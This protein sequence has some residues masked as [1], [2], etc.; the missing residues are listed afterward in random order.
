MLKVL[1]HE[2]DPDNFI[3][4]LLNGERITETNNQNKASFNNPEINTEMADLV[5]TIGAERAERYNALDA[6]I[7]GEDAPWAPIL[8]GAKVD[9]VSER[10]TGYLYHPVYGVDWA[11]MGVKQ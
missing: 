10:V 3:D 8:N 11:M 7:I 4:T 1:V 9:I 5:G 6:K 2:P